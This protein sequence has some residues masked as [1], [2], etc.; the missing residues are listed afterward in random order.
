MLLL[1]RYLLNKISVNTKIISDNKARIEIIT[2]L[3]ESVKGNITAIINDAGSELKGE[4]ELLN[5]VAKINIEIKNCKLWS[6]EN[7]FL[8]RFKNSAKT[9]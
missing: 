6:C 3:S 4:T 9:R 5:G 7:P 1:P 2:K 8:V